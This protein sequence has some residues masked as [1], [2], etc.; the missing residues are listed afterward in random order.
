MLRRGERVEMP[1]LWQYNA[2][3]GPPIKISLAD[4]DVVWTGN[5][6]NSD[7]RICVSTDGA[8][9]FSHTRPY[10]ET[11]TGVVTG[12][13]TH[14]YDPN[15]AYVIFSQKSVPK[16]LMTNDLGQ[17]WKDI[18]GY[19]PGSTSTGF[20]DVAVY[21]LL[22]M[23]WDTD[24]IWAGTEIG[25][26]E[27]L[28][29]G[30]TWAFADNGLPAVSVWE[31]KIVNNELIV[32]THGRGIWTLNTDPFDNTSISSA[33]LLAAEMNVYPNP[34]LTNA[35][36]DYDLEETQRIRVSIFNLSGQQ[37]LSLDQGTRTEGSHSLELDVS[38]L[39]AGMYM[40]HLE[41]EKGRF[42]RK[43]IVN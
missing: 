36:I 25:I 5:R 30:E 2:S 22:V 7:S 41:G 6:I 27:T 21:S 20:P 11:V 14:P 29:G 10:D 19:G 18:S 39:N 35:R 24:V 13:A 31:M 37:I 42:V 1:E 8:L 38:T 32:A 9:S 12:L 33:D 26:F 28:D 34:A 3:W 15:T 40:I 23:P 43:L 4:P 16:I 17:T